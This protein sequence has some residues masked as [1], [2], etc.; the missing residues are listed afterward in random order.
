[1]SKIGI[2]EMLEAGA[3][4]GHQ[5]RRWNPKMSKFIFGPRN[6]IHIIDLQQT[7]GL[8]SDAYTFIAD[9]VASG[10]KVLFVGTKK[11]AQDAIAE[12]ATR[13][14]QY[15]VNNRWLGG[16]LTNF[17][18]IKQSVDRLRA[19]E[20][21][22]KDGTFEKLPKKEVVG[23]TRE[24]AK[25]EKNLSGVKDM[26]KLPKAIF[27]IDPNL[28]RI[29]VDEARK[30]GICIVATLDT[31]CNPDLIDL[32]IPANDDSIRSVRLFVSNI[33]DACLEGVARHEELLA[34]KRASGELKEEGSEESGHKKASKR[35]Q[36]QIEVIHAVAPH[37]AETNGHSADVELDVELEMPEGD[38]KFSSHQL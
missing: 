9:A 1:M 8:M 5:T 25:L 31:N 36:P 38:V 21:M 13:S 3:H 12:E 37:V 24:L 28:E 7:V 30:L 20:T 16:M 35:K 32:P 10:G 29:A 4:F 26:T 6:G 27:V 2:R 17:K 18:T 22:S 19:I 33:A 34:Q 15:Y 11:Q 14:G 23:L